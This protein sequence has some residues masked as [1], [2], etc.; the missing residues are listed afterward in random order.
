[1]SNLLETIKAI[2]P[3][4]R[5]TDKVSIIR[6]Q[7]DTIEQ[8]RE[9]VVE[10]LQMSIA[11]LEGTNTEKAKAVNLVYKPEVGGTYAVGA[12]YGIRWLPNL[13]GKG[14]HLFQHVERDQLV[15][16][17]NALVEYVEAGHSDDDLRQIQRENAERMRDAA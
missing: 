12:K 17:L 5:A 11:V 6:K 14:E 16:V 7:S 3:N 9:K 10:K 4:A 13:A 15:P 2:A 1:M 8:A